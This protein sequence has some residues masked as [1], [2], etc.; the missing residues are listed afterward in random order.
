MQSQLERICST[1]LIP[2]E[3]ATMEA[4]YH[5]HN[6]LD[7]FDFRDILGT[8]PRRKHHYSLFSLRDKV[9]EDC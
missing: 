8:D 4:R 6:P 5:S 3:L 2:P 9:H 7:R 1:N